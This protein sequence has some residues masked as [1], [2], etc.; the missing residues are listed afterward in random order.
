MQ[1]IKSRT[2]R[3]IE[4]S[5]GLPMSKITNMSIEEE[6]E[7]IEK[8]SGKKVVFQKTKDSRK[9]SRGNVL[10]SLGRIMTINDVNKKLDKIK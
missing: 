9:M 8:K 1:K 10:L 7:Y 6:I 2:K 3:N 4:H 5:I